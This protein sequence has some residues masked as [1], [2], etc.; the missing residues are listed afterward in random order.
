MPVAL[1]DQGR[2]H[3]AS[4]FLTGKEQYPL[5]LE[6]WKFVSNLETAVNLPPKTITTT[7]TKKKAPPPHP[8][9]PIKTTHTYTH[10]HTHTQSNMKV[11]ITLTKKKKE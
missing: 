2:S 8:P 9:T 1:G 4:K 10:T 6:Q 11:N 7:H 3:I 5:P